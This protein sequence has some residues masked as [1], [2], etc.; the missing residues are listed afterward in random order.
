[1]RGHATRGPRAWG[2]G[3]G[4]LG[5]GQAFPVSQCACVAYVCLCDYISETLAGK[6]A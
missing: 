3:G 4:L 1:M 6:K 5:P 2:M